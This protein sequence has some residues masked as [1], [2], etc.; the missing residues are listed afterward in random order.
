MTKDS[1]E[2]HCAEL[3]LLSCRLDDLTE[4]FVYEFF[5]IFKNFDTISVYQ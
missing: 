2:N 4:V 3:S 5:V 1:K